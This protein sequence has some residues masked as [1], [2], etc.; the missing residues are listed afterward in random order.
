MGPVGAKEQGRGKAGSRVA[1]GRAR[2][3]PR[4]SGELLRAAPSCW[5]ARLGAFRGV[6]VPRVGLGLRWVPAYCR[7]FL[8]GTETL[9][10]LGEPRREEGGEGERWKAA[11][12]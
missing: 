3:T 6:F 10:F 1:P 8:L 12:C 9:T 11:N 2:N 5:R 4:S 7:L